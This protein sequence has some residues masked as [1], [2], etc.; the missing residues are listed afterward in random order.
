MLLMAFGLLKEEKL[1]D[2]KKRNRK[3]HMSQVECIR[4]SRRGFVSSTSGTMRPPFV[5]NDVIV[6]E[7]LKFA[8]KF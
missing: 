6:G 3:R 2:K 5:R 4:C 8:I 1:S 7:I